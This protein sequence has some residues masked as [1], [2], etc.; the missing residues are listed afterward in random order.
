[1]PCNATFIKQGLLTPPCGIPSPVG[2]NRPSSST[3]ALSHWRTSPRAGKVPS[4]VR[5]CWWLSR[6][7]A[8]SKSASSTH[9]RL[10]SLRTAV[11]W[12]ATIASWQPRPGRNP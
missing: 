2:V 11:V 10:A 1:M 6:S 8:A 3:P 9:S 4:E 7:K 12:M 5:M